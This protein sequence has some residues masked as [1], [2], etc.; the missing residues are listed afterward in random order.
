MIAG[1]AT[2]LIAG[3]VLQRQLR[4]PPEC[5]PQSLNRYPTTC[6][7]SVVANTILL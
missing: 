2:E 6:G 4:V 7:A 5:W 3:A 1:N